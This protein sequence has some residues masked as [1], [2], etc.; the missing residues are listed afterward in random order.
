[1]LCRESI[2]SDALAEYHRQAQIVNRYVVAELLQTDA[3]I[4]VIRREL[5]RLFDTVKVSEEEIRVILT[6]DVLKRD[7]LDGELPK[8]AKAMVKKAATT[9][10]KRQAKAAATESP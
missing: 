7:T 10:A 3:V 8:E 6:N 2:S 5:R 1:M 4:A 9:L